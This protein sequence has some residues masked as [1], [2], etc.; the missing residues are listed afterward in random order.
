[1][2]AANEALRA[3]VDALRKTPVE[4]FRAEIEKGVELDGWRMKPPAMEQG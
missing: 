2:L 3:K 4:F 1:M